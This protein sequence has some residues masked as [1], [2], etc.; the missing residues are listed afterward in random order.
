MYGDAAL[1]VEENW[2]TDK[3][4]D[5]SDSTSSRTTLSFLVAATADIAAVRS[6]PRAISLVGAWYF[7]AGVGVLII[8][9]L[10]QNLS[11]WSMGLPFAVG[12]L[13]MAATLYLT[14]GE[15]DA[16]V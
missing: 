10:D 6:L 3:V 5:L 8:S 1:L 9:S 11:P 12:Q 2:M 7:V 14:S 15:Y 13:L 16:R 4:R